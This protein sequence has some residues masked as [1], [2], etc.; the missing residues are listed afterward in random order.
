MTIQA[1][2]D[3]LAS[4][5]TSSVALVQ[6]ALQRVEELKKF[7]AIGVTSPTALERAAS[8]DQERAQGRV[9]GPL[10]GIVI[11]IK[12]NILYQDGTPTTAN[13]YALRDLMP[14]YNA[15]LVERLLE[16]GAIIL[17]KANL[18]E[19]ANFITTEGLP[20]GY[21]SMYGQVRHPYDETVDPLG[22]STGS[23]VAVALSIVPASIGTET[24]GSLL[25]PAFYNQVVTIKPTQGLVSQHGIVP[26]SPSQ[27]TAGPF[28]TTVVDAALLLEAMTA[29]TGVYTSGLSIP[30][31]G[32]VLWV[33]MDGWLGEYLPAAWVE[34]MKTLA[35]P[36]LRALGL[37]VEERVVTP[38]VIAN[39]LLLL[40]EYA[41]AMDAFLRS[42]G[43][44]YPIQSM[45]D[46]IAEYQRYPDQAMKYGIT[47]LEASLAH[48]KEANDFEYMTLKADQFKR[49][50]FAETVLN[51][52]YIAIVTV[53][54]TDWGAIHGNPSVQVPEATWDKH[55]RGVTLIGKRGDDAALLALA[56]H[57]QQ[58]VR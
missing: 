20:N 45:E 27:D 48:R 13:S 2:R 28:A 38:E 26:I 57:Y 14:P 18:T 43:P 51:E 41:P 12:D 47:L 9:R 5:S 11:V 21:G 55:P 40:S 54:W 7:N 8:L 49:S 32:K 52:G 34:T 39:E 53:A 23:A 19:L 29:Q 58:L 3:A 37:E 17:G 4:G 31:H 1:M 16:A 30:P 10:H 25:A 15:L 6:A 33:T 22:S 24:N 50:S 35:I 42:L 36:R 56:H 44:Q 46:L